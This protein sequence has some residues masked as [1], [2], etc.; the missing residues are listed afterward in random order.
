MGWIEDGSKL[1][2]KTGLR[3]PSIY[4]SEVH[5]HTYIDVKSLSMASAPP[6]DENYKCH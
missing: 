5:I 4:C 2:G 1:S 6:A 3:Y